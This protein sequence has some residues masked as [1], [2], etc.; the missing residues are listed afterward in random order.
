MNHTTEKKRYGVLLCIN[1]TGILNSWLQKNAFSG[2]AY[3]EINN[4][5]STAPIGSD[6]L[7]CYPFGNGAERVLENKDLGAMMKNLQFNRHNRSHLAR[8][9]QEGIAFALYYGMEIMIKMGL[10]IKTIR[11]GKANMFL[12]EIFSEAF[13]NTS[14]AVVELFNTDG[15]QGAARAAGLGAGIYKNP[16]ECF[17]GLSILKRIEPQH[18]L[19]EQYKEAYGSW[20]HGLGL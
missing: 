17:N 8:A 15:A 18:Q 4:I 5:A 19:Q 7:Q 16:N 20:K 11:A 9:A 14:G 6:G 1:G 2:I 10:Q 13:S 3:P 12:S